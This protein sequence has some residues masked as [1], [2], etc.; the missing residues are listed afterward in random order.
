M[1]IATDALSTWQKHIGDA[2]RDHGQEFAAFLAGAVDA[3]QPRGVIET[4]A[5]DSLVAEPPPS[6]DQ[7]G[8]RTDFGERF[9]KSFEPVGAFR[10]ARSLEW[11]S[12]E[13]AASR[14]LGERVLGPLAAYL[15]ANVDEVAV[16]EST[17]P[18]IAGT[19]LSFPRIVFMNENVMSDELR[20]AEH[21]IHESVHAS[22]YSTY[23]LR[24]PLS[25]NY[26]L[27]SRDF[28]FCA[29]WHNTTVDTADET[30]WWGPERSMHAFLVYVH[31]Y[32]FWVG[33]RKFD[34]DNEVAKTGMKSALFCGRFMG[35]QLVRAGLEIFTPATLAMIEDFLRLLPVAKSMD[36]AIARYFEPAMRVIQRDHLF[37]ARLA[38]TPESARIEV[39]SRGRRMVRTEESAYALSRDLDDL[40]AAVDDEDFVDG[41][42]FKFMLER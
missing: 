20:L 17:I 26:V 9:A 33:V 21:L 31:L 3:S 42:V 13:L 14:E 37:S 23:F 35:Q 28:K 11:S 10:M 19:A 30:W 5:L 34:P 16:V 4:N 38:A 18:F 24:T 8:T 1:S 27:G 29:V 6:V 25:R 22:V 15:F 12:D 40:L 39:S 41:D 7:A 2:D 36:D 32:A